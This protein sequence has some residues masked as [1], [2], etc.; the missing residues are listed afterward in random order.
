MRATAS[1]S[2]V[3][4][5]KANKMAA[6]ENSIMSEGQRLTSQYPTFQLQLIENGST[7]SAAD[8]NSIRYELKLFEN[9]MSTTNPEE[10]LGNTN[11][12]YLTCVPCGNTPKSNRF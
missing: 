8:L 7:F 2:N 5:A 4:G 10:V 6:I 9:A 3:N 12:Q 1:L 11:F